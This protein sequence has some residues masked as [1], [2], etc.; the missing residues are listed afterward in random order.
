MPTLTDEQ[1]AQLKSEGYSL[2]EILE[3]DGYSPEEIS[4]IDSPPIPSGS[5]NLSPIDLNTDLNTRSD[6][7]IN[8]NNIAYEQ[9]KNLAQ[10]QSQTNELMKEGYNQAAGTA[11]NIVL[12]TAG[13][14]LAPQAKIAKGLPFAGRVG[15]YGINALGQALGV[16]VGSEIGQQLGT[17]ES[18]PMSKDIQDIKYN[19]ILGAAIPTAMDAVGTATQFV[20][21]FFNKAPNVAKQLGAN[22]TDLN[23]EAEKYI[24]PKVEELMSNSDFFNKEVL[25]SADPIKQYASTKSYRQQLGK[26]IGDFYQSNPSIPVFKED[27][28]NS[29]NF[30]KLTSIANDP[31]LTSS[32]KKEAADVLSIFSSLPDGQAF[33]LADVWRLRQDLD[34]QLVSSLYR[35]GTGEVT[36]LSEYIKEAADSVRGAME[37]GIAKAVARGELSQELAEKLLK[38]K[39]EFS[40]LS[41][42]VEVLG[43][44]SGQTSHLRIIDKIPTDLR[45]VGLAAT[46][47]YN[48]LVAAGGLGALALKSGEARAFAQRLGMAGQNIADLASVI[49]PYSGIGSALFKRTTD[50]TQINSNELAMSV[51]NKLAALVGPETAQAQAM[52]IEEIMT[53]GNPEVKKQLITNLSTNFPEMFE[54]A[55]EGVITVDNQYVSPFDK[56]AIVKNSLDLP[57]SERAKRI[58]SAF[59]NKYVP[60]SEAAATPLPAASPLPVDLGNLNTSLDSALAPRQ[61]TPLDNS[62]NKSNIA[63]LEELTSRQE[64]HN[65]YEFH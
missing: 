54:P 46:T 8:A 11:S 29:E 25:T 65:E 35:K 47:A 33:D 61:D 21:S 44:K 23:P 9:N 2:Q 18:Q 49:S 55:T 64:L 39:Q 27:I 40:N 4:S 42:I 48:P 1:I 6:L 32:T 22:I 52:E 14:L 62:Y 3:A 31:F 53:N 57:P 17:R 37:L 59:Q 26:Q 12:E 58:G 60:P 34:T 15:R 56:D 36:N 50:L 16:Q 24:V 10:A 28:L 30:K 38:A 43:R 51:F 20:R 7:P 13:G 41:P 45:A 63:M 5:I 19:T